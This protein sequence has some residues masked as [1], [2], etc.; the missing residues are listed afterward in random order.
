MCFSRCVPVG[1][2]K[3]PIA[4][5]VQSRASGS[6]KRNEPQFE[7]KPR[8]TSTEDWYQV[9]CCAPLSVRFLRATLVEAKKMTGLPP[10]LSASRDAPPRASGP[11]LA[12]QTV[13]VAGDFCMPPLTL[14]IM[15]AKNRLGHT[16]GP[17]GHVG[18]SERHR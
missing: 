12:E 1:D 4:I 9:R 17:K 16:I 14:T 7:Q 8:R 3:A 11:A 15:G 10:A 13:H 5:E 18:V 6:Q 2:S